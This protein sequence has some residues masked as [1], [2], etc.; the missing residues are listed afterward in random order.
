MSLTYALDAYHAGR[1][2]DALAALAGLP[3]DVTVVHTRCQCHYLL[4]QQA[5]ALKTAKQLALLT[6]NSQA[7]WLIQGMI[8]PPQQALAAMAKAQALGELDYTGHDVMAARHDQLHQSVEAARH[9]LASLHL[10]DAEAE[11]LKLDLPLCLRQPPK[12]DVAKPGQ[13]LIAIALWGDTPCYLHGALANARLAKEMFPGWTCRFQIGPGVPPSVLAD[14][15][16]Y[17][18]QLVD[19]PPFRHATE[20]MLWRF[21]TWEDRQA[22]RFMIRDA[23]C[24]FTDQ[25]RLAVEAWVASDRPFHAMRGHM[26]H[27]ELLLG[28]LWGGL[29]RILP[30][31][32]ALLKDFQVGH[33]VMDQVFLRQRVWPLIKDRL[34][35][36][37][38]CPETPGTTPFPA[39]PPLPAGRHVGQGI[40]KGLTMPL[41]VKP[42]QSPL[43]SVLMTAYNAAPWI[44]DAVSSI[45][46]Q[47][48]ADFELII[49]DDGSTDGTLE[50]VRPLLA[51]PRVRLDR[52]PRNGGPSKAL[53]RAL[54]LSR[55][56]YLC[57]MDADD[58]ALPQRLAHSRRW[59]EE[60]PQC[61]A[62][63]GGMLLWQPGKPEQ[64]VSFSVTP[65]QTK[66]AAMV[67]SPLHHG[68]SAFRRQVIEANIR[69]REDF[70]IAQDYQFWNEVL[71]LGPCAT[72]PD[73]V[74]KYRMHPAQSSTRA[75]SMRRHANRARVNYL[76]Q[77]GFLPTPEE[78]EAHLALVEPQN[79]M[80]AGGVPALSAWV[81]RLLRWNEQ[82]RQF[83]QNLLTVMLTLRLQSRRQALV[84]PAATHGAVESI[85]APWP[86][87]ATPPDAM[88]LKLIQ[89]L[90]TA[91]KNA[92]EHRSAL[93]PQILGLDGMSS[94]K[95][96]HFLNN[97]LADQTKD[98]HYLEIGCWKGSTLVAALH[99]NPV[100]HTAI[101][102]FTEFGGPKQEFHANCALIGRPVN[103]KEC[104]ALGVDILTLNLPK[105]TVYFYDGGHTRQNHADALTHYFDAMDDTFIFIVD[106]WN[107]HDVQSGT[108]DGIQQCGLEV[109]YVKE[110]PARFNGDKDQWW[111]GLGVFV[112]R[113]KI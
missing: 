90:N 89:R 5:E 94:A 31:V 52:L 37:D 7:P 113:K 79:P 109:L 36:H 65:E 100:K 13:N 82:A 21:R 24:V 51:D 80:P 28:G 23:D 4:G 2:Q 59:L 78:L 33:S 27:S 47:T 53:N 9:R 41:R 29:T 81:R 92:A 67:N 88:A 40:T 106:D 77:V 71:A 62:V 45:L 66:I 107:F 58:I 74:L 19:L 39:H 1:Y 102:N 87:M 95:C 111:N 60:N 99:N 42:E 54:D 108:R 11:R 8:L 86:A 10:K 35:V 46:S 32:D 63:S 69:Y 75:D 49:V 96:R 26:A 22:E 70:P 56:Q 57:I 6:P 72:F 64:T 30:P 34:L 17:G 101:D 16:A 12:F 105:V 97:L 104:D 73:V 76:K 50:V 83:D 18:A 20:G 103:F 3:E 38:C 14:L 68:A 110:L 55:G 61:A 43:F 93:T 44:K 98:C 91:I 84:T 48:E 112:L 15:Q 25:E 85:A